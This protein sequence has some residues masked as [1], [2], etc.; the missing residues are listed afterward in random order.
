[1]GGGWRRGGD[2][3]A[4]AST[5]VTRGGARRRLSRNHRAAR[6]SLVARARPAVISVHQLVISGRESRESKWRRSRARSAHRRRASY[7]SGVRRDVD[8]STPVRLEVAH[9]GA[10]PAGDAQQRHAVPL[11]GVLSRAQAR[12][13]SDARAG[14]L[15]GQ[16]RALWRVLL[17]VRRDLLRQVRFARH[18]HPRRRPQVRGPHGPR[19]HRLRMAPPK[20]RLRGALRIRLRHR[21]FHVSHRRPRRQLRH[22]QG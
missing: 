4:H 8:V 16:R 11:P 13:R 15:R 6:R 3:R 10:V 1:M 22:L 7:G 20:S 12:A 14:E 9:S 19:G 2:A 5:R 21:L 17:G 18:P